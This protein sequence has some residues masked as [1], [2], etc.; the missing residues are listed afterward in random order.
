MKRI[1]STKHVIRLGQWLLLAGIMLRALIPVGYMLDS[2][3]LERGTSLLII[4]PTGLEGL[5]E[6]TFLEDIFAERTSNNP[7]DSASPHDHGEQLLHDNKPCVFAAMAVIAV[8]FVFFG[9]LLSLW[10]SIRNRVAP[11]DEKRPNCAA[12]GVPSVRAP[13]QYS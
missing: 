8:A 3:S 9:F 13:P 1:L 11:V 2:T 5:V 10:P 12:L 6:G 7:S 4:C